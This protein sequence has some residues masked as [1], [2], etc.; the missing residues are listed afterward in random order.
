ASV[1]ITN[2]SGGMHLAD[3]VRT[4]VVVT[5]GGTELPG[6]LRPRSAPAVLLG[7]AVACAP[8][9]QLHCPFGH[10]CLDV[11]PDEVAAAATS[12]A[13]T[14]PLAGTVSP[15]SPVSLAATGTGHEPVPTTR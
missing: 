9:R 15:V 11:P 12:L 7:R 8:C 10:E 6:D 14:P 2:N 13:A 4:P 1:A 5:Y 3:A